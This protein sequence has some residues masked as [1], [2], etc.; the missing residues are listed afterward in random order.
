VNPTRWQC[1]KKLGVERGKGYTSLY[2][3]IDRADE[4]LMK[5]LPLRWNERRK[6]ER[7]C[8]RVQ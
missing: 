2:D 6:E 1:K 5:L 4:K 7:K 3:G 8:C